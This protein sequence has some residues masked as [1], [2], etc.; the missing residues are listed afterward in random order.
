MLWRFAKV[1]FLWGRAAVRDGG[2]RTYRLVFLLEDSSILNIYTYIIFSDRHWV[3][4]GY[5]CH[6]NVTLKYLFWIVRM[7]A[8]LL[9]L[10]A[11]CPWLKPAFRAKRYLF[12]YAEG[13]ISGKTYVS[14]KSQWGRPSSSA[15]SD[16]HWRT[17]DTQN[18][19]QAS[20]RPQVRGKTWGKKQES[21]LLSLKSNHLGSHLLTGHLFLLQGSPGV[22]KPSLRFCSF[23]YGDV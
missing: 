17:Q 10:S 13:Q 16:R 15:G 20:V 8:S 1:F 2:R 7:K 4:G 6:V 3:Y 5:L 19:F 21:L 9:V 18:L 12:T 14:P 23:T 11:L 22:Y